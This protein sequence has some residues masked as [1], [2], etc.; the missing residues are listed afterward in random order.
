VPTLFLWGDQDLALGRLAATETARYVNSP[1]QFEILDGYSHWLLEE[2]PDKIGALVL[3][4]LT[5]NP[6]G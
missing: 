5:A 4:H 6:L 2:A 3:G 1:Y